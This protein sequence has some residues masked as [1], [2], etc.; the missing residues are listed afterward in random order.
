MAI[1]FRMNYAEME[2]HINAIKKSVEE[3]RKIQ[4]E[5][6]KVKED[7]KGKSYVGNTGNSIA[8]YIEET[9][10]KIDAFIQHSNF[11]VDGLTKTVAEVRGPT[12][13]TMEGRFKK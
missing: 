5:L 9:N 1:D 7:L 8:A 11:L 12:E 13:D 2:A 6:N 4:G 10:K 3:H